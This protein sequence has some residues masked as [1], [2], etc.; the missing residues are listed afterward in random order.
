M[1]IK[2]TSGILLHITSLPS[3][4][5]VGDFGPAA[6]AFADFL[7]KARQGCWQMLPVNPPAI[8]VPHSPY[9]CASAFAG[10][11]LL[12]SPQL[13]YRRGL[14]GREDIRQ[15]PHFPETKV[16]FGRV[17]GFKRKLLNAAF[18]NFSGRPTQTAYTEFCQNNKAWLDDFAFFI[19][20]RD[21]YKTG[22]WRRWPAELRDRRKD[23]LASF[24]RKHRKA[25]EKQ[26]FMQYIFFR[27]QAFLKLYCNKLG[28][29]IIG[30]I[31]IYV[32][33]KS[34]DVWANPQFFKLNGAKKPAF[35]SGVPPDFFS[36]T[37]Q[38]WGNPIY[39]WRAL[40]RKGY[41]WWL[42]RIGHNLQMFDIVRIDHFRAL[43]AYWQIPAHH[44]TAVKGKWIRAPKDD[45]FRKVL[46]RFPSCPF[47]VEDMGNITPAVR[48]FIKKHKLAGM[49]VLQFG[50]G[51]GDKTNPHAPRNHV[52]NCVVYTGTHD[53]NTTTGWFENELTDDQR[54]KLSRRPWWGKSDDELHWRFVRLAMNSP[55]NLAIIPM[56]DILGLGQDGRMNLPGTFSEKNW[57]WRMA[58]G[59][60][61][62]SI[63]RKLAR[64]TR[65]ANRA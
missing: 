35:V 2:R 11:P 56:Q 61:T 15:L 43:I 54:Q 25:I 49:R 19:A 27:Q 24:R 29:R 63:T 50:L 39:D 33:Y 20:L 22:N 7:A 47:V 34:A 28:I 31:P 65:A 44:K 26:K 57:V 48:A 51:A 16:N 45:F 1:K 36:K 12:I 46:E 42:D 38:L 37:G 17:I 64:I 4:F 32:S 52:K 3:K 62:P 9:N 23:A 5:G 55:A 14:L 30:D 59:R 8:D 58:P 6:F 18:R 60:I 10:N 53:N 13:L 21:L 41:S 40:K